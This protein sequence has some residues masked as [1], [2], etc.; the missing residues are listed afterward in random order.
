MVDTLGYVAGSV[1]LRVY[2][3]VGTEDYDFVCLGIA[4]VGLVGMR[5][6]L[7]V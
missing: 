3:K 1:W 2:M 7:V 5:Y 4:G 6:L